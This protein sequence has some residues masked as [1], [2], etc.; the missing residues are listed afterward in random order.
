MAKV[1]MRLV[2]SEVLNDTVARFCACSG[3]SVKAE[4][5]T[6]HQMDSVTLSDTLSSVTLSDILSSCIRV[7]IVLN[8]KEVQNLIVI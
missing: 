5:C 7:C 2:E 6:E 8:V 1:V 3:V 4:V